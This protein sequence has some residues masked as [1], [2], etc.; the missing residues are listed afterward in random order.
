MTGSRLGEFRSETEVDEFWKQLH[1]R[2]KR[3]P[4]PLTPRTL[5]MS[6]VNHV[7]K[8]KTSENAAV[9]ACTKSVKAARK[10]SSVKAARKTPKSRL[11]KRSSSPAPEG[12]GSDYLQPPSQEY[13]MPEYDAHGFGRM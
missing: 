12:G 10:K 1:V 13:D 9:D 8:R 6:I 3:F 7:P 4:N 11:G 2:L 5:A